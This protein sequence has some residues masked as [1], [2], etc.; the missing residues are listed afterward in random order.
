VFLTLL[1]FQTEVIASDTLRLVD[2]YKSAE[3]K[4][5]LSKKIRQEEAA[6]ELRQGILTSYFL[7]QVSLTGKATYQ[8]QLLE[9]PFT[10]PGAE[11]IDFYKDNYEVALNVEQLVFDGGAVAA[12]KDIVELENEYV[13]QSVAV[14]IYA[15]H[16]KINDAYF[17]ILLADA[18]KSSLELLKEEL[19]AK[20][21]II[22]SQVRNGISTESNADILK[23]E[24]LKT[25]QQ[26]LETA[27]EREAAGKVLGEYVGFKITKYTTFGLPNPA[28]SPNKSAKKSRPEYQRFE[29]SRELLEGYDGLYSSE[30]YPKITGFFQ[31][32]YGRPSL[33]VFETDLKGYYI[34]GVQAKWTLWNWQKTGRER[35]ILQVQKR[36]TETEEETFSKNIAVAAHKSQS[37][38]KKLGALLKTDREI[39]TL[40]ER[41]AKHASSKLDNG[42]ITATDYLTD[43][44]A[45]IQAKLTMDIH[46]IQ[47]VKAKVQYLTI[48]GEM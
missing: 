1:F 12:Q 6:E 2:C 26:L 16:E 8:S 10:V 11:P 30:Y 18:R 43:L 32:A 38:V 36:I 46:Q 4:Y 48:I 45:K 47:L 21:E 27:V 5:P 15:L 17:N 7:P 33:N 42:L 3:R 40:R 35:E 13:A 41:I 14:D 19:E 24:L 23:A 44:N 31:C 28:Y 34:A 37:Q 22:V 9:L 39:I 29:L 20:L 25:E